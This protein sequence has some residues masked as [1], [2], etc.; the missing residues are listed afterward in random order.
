MRPSLRGFG[1]SLSPRLCPYRHWEPSRG[2]LEGRSPC[3]REGTTSWLKRGWAGH[4]APKRGAGY[5]RRVQTRGMS[6]GAANGA[7]LLL[8]WDTGG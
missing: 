7:A 3:G 2:L 5:T 6:A 4:R 8:L 1:A